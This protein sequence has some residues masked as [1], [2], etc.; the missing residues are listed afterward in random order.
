MRVLADNGGY[1]FLNVGD[2]AML[3]VAL[4]RLQALLPN[5][6]FDVLT[7]APS[8]LERL[9]P[10]VSAVLPPTPKDLEYLHRRHETLYSWL[11]WRFFLRMQQWEDQRW[12]LHGQWNLSPQGRTYGGEVLKRLEKANAV[13]ATGGGYLTSAFSEQARSVLLLLAVAQFRGKPTI[14]FGQGI[15]PIAPGALYQLAAHVLPRADLICLREKVHG[16]SLLKELGVDDSRIRITGD[17]AVETAWTKR[18]PDLGRMIGLNFRKSKY[19]GINAAL[20]SSIAD[21]A[22]KA[23]RDYG[24]RIIPL[25][26]SHYE[27]EDDGGLVRGAIRDASLLADAGPPPDP[28]EDYAVATAGRCRVVVACSYHAAL[29]SLAQG[30]PAIT[31]VHSRYYDS[32]FS[33]LADLF[34]ADACRIWRANETPADALYKWI[35]EHWENA[36][37]L[38]PRLLETADSQINMGRQ[39]YQESADLL[40]RQCNG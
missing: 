11:P 24:T 9:C 10:G 15:G 25:P 18:M 40:L 32:K 23:A 36:P 5:A 2:T 30:I 12:L 20:M 16:Y 14:L 8:V 33:G 7:K 28:T 4:R 22:C 31:I 39:A 13:V 35:R 17:D 34:G 38:R 27:R 1:D 37:Q 29:F 26:V 3:R 19:S 21:A 6:Q